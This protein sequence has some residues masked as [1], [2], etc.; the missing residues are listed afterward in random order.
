MGALIIRIGC[1]GPLYYNY[2][3]EPQN[4]IGNYF[5]LYI[6]RRLRAGA[7]K[8]LSAG[9]ARDMRAQTQHASRPVYSKLGW[10]L[11]APNSMRT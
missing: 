6:M 9:I 1:W 5:G 7:L 10:S 4:S 11:K 8:H 3:K 2:N